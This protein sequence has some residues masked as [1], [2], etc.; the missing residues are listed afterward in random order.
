MN[1]VALLRE[2]YNHMAWA[3]SEVWRT[4]SAIDPTPDDEALHTLLAHIHFTQEAFSAIWTGREFVLR[5]PKDFAS[6]DEIRAFALPFYEQI[7]DILGG[8]D[9]ESLAAPMPVPWA[10]YFARSLGR[11]PEGT[12][13][14]ETMMQVVLH[15]QYHR[16]Q[17]NTR[18][19]TLG[20][21]P[22]MVDYIGW[23]W[24]G[25]PDAAW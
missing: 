14:G 19:R 8:E 18:I 2:L 11:E 20:A 7:P 17:I 12:T 5:R 1:D 4:V 24:A 23:L 16:G 25:R 13:R 15:T 3:D 6:L 22:P 9:A 21:T 10:K